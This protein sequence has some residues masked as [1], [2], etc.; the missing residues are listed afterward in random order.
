MR[1]IKLWLWTPPTSI[2]WAK[3]VNSPS[4]STTNRNITTT[5]RIEIKI[6]TALMETGTA[7][8]PRRWQPLSFWLV[9]FLNPI[10]SQITLSVYS[11]S[12]TS[13]SFSFTLPRNPNFPLFYWSITFKFFFTV[14]TRKEFMKFVIIRVK[15]F[16]LD[17][18][19][20]NLKLYW[21]FGFI[22]ILEE[23]AYFEWEKSDNELIEAIFCFSDCNVTCAYV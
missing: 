18:A 22:Y 14:V 4:L 16:R 19:I 12:G 8:C 7:T 3:Q 20:E 21:S 17:K 11:V 6:T 15:K 23:L 1:P 2:S 13:I 10:L 5:R 9:F